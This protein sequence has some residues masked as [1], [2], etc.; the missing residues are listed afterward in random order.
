VA[1]AHF[2]IE[3]WFGKRESLR[4]YGLILFRALEQLRCGGRKLGIAT[5]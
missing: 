5:Q 4:E 2:F 3:G 1:S